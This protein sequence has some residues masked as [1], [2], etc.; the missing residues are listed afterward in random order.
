MVLLFPYKG[1]NP[2]MEVP[3]PHNL[4]QTQLPLDVQT[5]KY[6]HTLEMTVQPMNPGG[7]QVFH[8]QHEALAESKRHRARLRQ[9]SSRRAVLTLAFL[10][11]T[12][13]PKF[14]HSPWYN[15]RHGSAVQPTSSPARGV[16]GSLG[17]LCSSHEVSV[18]LLILRVSLKWVNSPEHSPHAK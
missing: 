4:I 7:T 9:S 1:T 6:W 5:S 13:P 10:E 18:R 16:S 12:W 15:S 2:I 14:R 3:P 11:G 8:A 17:G